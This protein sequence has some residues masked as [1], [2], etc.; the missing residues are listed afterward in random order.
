MGY[1]QLT[2]EERCEIARLRAEGAPLREIAAALD[3]APSTIARELNRNSTTEDGYRPRYADQQARARRWCGARLERDEELCTYVLAQLKRGWSPEQVAGRLAQESGRCVISHE[4]IYRFIY[5]QI[6]RTNDYMWRR[7]LPRG[8]SKRGRRQRGRS[9]PASFIAHRRPL[10]ERP[11]AAADRQTFGHWEAD[12]MQFGRSGQA[13][14]ALHERHSRLLIAVRLASKAAAP[15]AEA[16]AAILGPLPPEFRQT[17]TFDNGTEFAHHYELHPWGIATYFCD[18]YS[19]W[20]KGGVEN[21]IGRMRRG[22]PRKTDLVAVP[23]ASFTELFRAYNNTPRKCLGY[24]TPAEILQDQ[25]LHFKC[26][27]TFQPSL[28]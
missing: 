23:E 27:S 17:V 21:G 19:P 15:V 1:R 3:R 20:Q 11:A 10:S 18:T 9:S 22:L 12:L 5:A 26:E 2:I 6:R 25:V 13:V 24:R 14:L 16:I 28:E 4:S 7:Y 8:K